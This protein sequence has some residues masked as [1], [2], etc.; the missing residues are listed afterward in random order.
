MNDCLHDNLAPVHN[1]KK[2]KH[3]INLWFWPWYNFVLELN[4]ILWYRTC[5]FTVTFIHRKVFCVVESVNMFK[6][7]N[8]VK[9]ADFNHTAQSTEFKR[10]YFWLAINKILFLSVTGDVPVSFYY[11][12]SALHVQVFSDKQFRT[13]EAEARRMTISIATCHRGLSLGYTCYQKTSYA[14]FNTP[15]TRVM[16]IKSRLVTPSPKNKSW[17]ASCLCIA[18][19]ECWLSSS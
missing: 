13:H 9:T 17:E 11:S 18:C 14:F 3:W 16:L 8:W 5:R 1:N 6:Y 2:K 4:Q 15:L 12:T 7:L 19:Y 10:W